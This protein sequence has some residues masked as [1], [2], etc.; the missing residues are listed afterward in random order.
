MKDNSSVEKEPLALYLT[1]ATV[2]GVIY[3]PASKH[4]LEGFLSMLEESES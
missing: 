2:D 3:I 4:F 1:I